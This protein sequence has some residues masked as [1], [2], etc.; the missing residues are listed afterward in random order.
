MDIN[1][2]MDISLQLSML[3]L[4]SIWIFLNFYGYPRIDL[5]WILDPGCVGC[6]TRFR[7]SEMR[8]SVILE[9]GYQVYSNQKLSFFSFLFSSSGQCDESSFYSSRYSYLC[10]TSDESLKSFNE[11]QHTQVNSRRLFPYL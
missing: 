7:A 4:I 8:F 1:V 9:S 3:L 10:T 2:F 6:E 5:L 11:V